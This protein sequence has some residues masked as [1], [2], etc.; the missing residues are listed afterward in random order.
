MTQTT[1]LGTMVLT[2]ALAAII[3]PQFQQPPE[4]HRKA[5]RTFEIAQRYNL[6]LRPVATILEPAWNAW[7]YLSV[8]AHDVSIKPWVMMP[9]QNDPFWAGGI[10]LPPWVVGRLQS[11]KRAG[12][13]FDELWIAHELP[14][15]VNGRRLHKRDVMPNMPV[16]KTGKRLGAAGSIMSTVARGAFKVGGALGG[17]FAQTSQYA[18]YIPPAP[19]AKPMSV[20]V[21]PAAYV[22][23]TETTV[24]TVA[25]IAQSTP[26]QAVAE[27]AKIVTGAVVR[28]APVVESAPAPE[29]KSFWTIV[30]QPVTEPVVEPVAEPVCAPVPSKPQKS[31]GWMD[32]MDRLSILQENAKNPYGFGHPGIPNLFREG[33]LWEDRRWVDERRNA[34]WRGEAVTPAQFLARQGYNNNVSVEPWQVRECA[35]YAPGCD[36]STDRYQYT[37]PNNRQWIDRETAMAITICEQLWPNHYWMDHICDGIVYYSGAGQR[38]QYAIHRNDIPEA[39]DPIL[40]GVHKVNGVAH[41]TYIAHWYV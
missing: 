5:S 33:S 40:F 12:I 16:R 26:S 21:A 10:P 9:I 27:V 18:E 30:S 38:T 36:M 23:K 3:L 11:M 2:H 6:P 25:R 32:A 7:G 20:S 41:M 31:E 19:K 35:T 13:D 28:P 1:D 17:L 8:P 14:R 34:I 4:L 22:P 39:L 24:E 29:P 37:V 15:Y